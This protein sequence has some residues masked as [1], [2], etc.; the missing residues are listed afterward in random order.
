M[1]R[2]QSAIKEARA[3]NP[4]KIIAAQEIYESIYKAGYEEGKIAGFKGVVDYLGIYE[5]DMGFCEMSNHI[6]YSKLKE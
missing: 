5:N 3:K 1:D 2:I 6:L 4:G